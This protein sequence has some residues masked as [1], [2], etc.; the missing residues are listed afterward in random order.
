MRLFKVE[1]EFVN[2]VVS[3][4]LGDTESQWSQWMFKRLKLAGKFSLG[5]VNKN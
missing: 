3:A 4:Q 2:F 5:K 1:K